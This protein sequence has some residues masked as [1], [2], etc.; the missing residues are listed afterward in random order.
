MKR[1]QEFFSTKQEAID[2][3]RN[4]SKIEGNEL[5]IHNKDGKIANRDSHGTIQ[6]PRAKINHKIF[7]IQL[8]EY[9]SIP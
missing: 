4:H 7:I 5:F 3:A 9:Q 6:P 8:Q 2:W 1:Y